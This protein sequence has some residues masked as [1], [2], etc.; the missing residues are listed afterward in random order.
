MMAQAEA[1]RGNP[2]RALILFE[3]FLGSA[4]DNERVHYE[5][6]SLLAT[7]LELKALEAVPDSLRDTAHT[8]FWRTRSGAAM[9]GADARRVEHYRRVWYA[10]NYFGRHQKPWDKRGE[11]YVR[12]GEPNYRS[13][14]GRENEIPSVAVQQFKILKVDE[15]LELR[16]QIREDEIG[17]LPVVPPP[18]IY[19]AS[20][21]L[22][23]THDRETQ[24]NY[25]Q[26][27]V[28][29]PGEMVRLNLPLDM[30]QGVGP[31]ALVDRD[32]SGNTMMAWESWVYLDIGKGIEFTFTDRYMNGN[33]DFPLVPTTLLNLQLVIEVQNSQPAVEFMYVS[34]AI[35]EKFTVPP[36]VEPLDFYYDLASFRSTSGQ[37]ELEV[38][39]GI[40]PDQIQSE[41]TGEFMRLK[42]AHDLIL[43]DEMGEAVY[44]TGDARVFQARVGV[45]KTGRSIRRY[46]PFICCTR[47]IYFGC[48][49]GG[50]VVW[51]MEFV[52]ARGG[53][54]FFC[55][56][57]GDQRFRIGVGGQ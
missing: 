9:L 37:P 57:V 42:L 22:F 46:R 34:S 21:N 43:V 39:F 20:Q 33:W 4:P 40:P 54:S 27:E 44:H 53:D 15:M 47:H 24:I 23:R 30:Q 13:R 38:Y 31:T 51:Q 55:R 17:E 1:A 45:D 10:R 16:G 2:G 3:Q 48:E 36:G 25:W 52:S 32:A 8:R 14:S 56:F 26:W 11:V 50:S 7:K 49:I 12:Y 5:D 18:E 29:T 6:L 19:Y 28:Q 41:R 35:P